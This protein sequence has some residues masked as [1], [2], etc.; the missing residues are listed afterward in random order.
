MKL[1]NLTVDVNAIENGTWVSDIPNLPGVRFLVAGMESKAY[2][3]A[4]AKELRT[5]T[6]RKE[7]VSGNL[8]TDRIQEIQRKLVAKHCLL[9]WDGVEDDDGNNVLYSETLAYQLMTEAQY[10]P[11]QQGVF[12]A[13]NLVDSGD[14]EFIEETEGN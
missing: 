12:Y 14:M 13:V 7:R 10:L 1:S 8:D 11:F 4:F 2:R 9:G 6:T 3:K 5:S